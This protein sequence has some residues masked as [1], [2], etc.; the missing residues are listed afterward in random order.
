M[1]GFDKY[2]RGEQL[3]A[4]GWEED[5]QTGTYYLTGDKLEQYVNFLR[6]TKFN[7]SFAMDLD[8]ILCPDNYVT[9]D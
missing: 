9:D 6:T 7:A 1:S 3:K 4:R 2:L 8:D 5:E